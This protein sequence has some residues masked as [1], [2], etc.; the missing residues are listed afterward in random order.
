MNKQN[1]N[2]KPILLLIITTI[3]LLKNGINPLIKNK[4]NQTPLFSFGDE[5]KAGAICIIN[6]LLNVKIN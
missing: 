4:Y 6:S 1:K 2:L 5:Y 3:I